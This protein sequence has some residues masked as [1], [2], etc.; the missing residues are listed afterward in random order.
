LWRSADIAEPSDPIIARTTRP[1]VNDMDTPY[2]E[3]PYPELL[4]E[5]IK[6]VQITESKLRAC[7]GELHQMAVKL[8]SAHDRIHQLEEEL[9]A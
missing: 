6:R 8:K 1:G 4:D 7:E 5:W 2:R 3:T 9:Q